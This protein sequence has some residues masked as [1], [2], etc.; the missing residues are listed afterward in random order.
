MG[1]EEGGLDVLPWLGGIMFVLSRD[2]LKVAGTWGRLE[3][4]TTGTQTK[5]EVILAGNICTHFLDKV[6][7]A[8]A[9]TDG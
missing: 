4:T 6:A 2:R 1:S 7:F 5:G 3:N 8:L 9:S